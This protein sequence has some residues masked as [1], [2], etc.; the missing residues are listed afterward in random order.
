L[1]TSLLA[2]E[3][4]LLRLF[5]VQTFHHFAYM[6][7]GVALLGFAASGTALV[8]IRR[9]VE[10]REAAL[11]RALSVLLPPALIAAP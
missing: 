8:L 11:F 5:A 2:F 10:G 3:V 6:A 9:R 4:V 7:I 1:S